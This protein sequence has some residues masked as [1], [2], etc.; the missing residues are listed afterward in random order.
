MSVTVRARLP[1]G[2][3][4]GLDHLE[5]TLAD[6]PDAVHVV[7]ALVRADTIEARPHDE[8]DPRC[9]KTVILHLEV[10]T[11]HD[12]DQADKAMRVVYETRTGKTELPFED[13]E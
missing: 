4:N 10:V 13:G 1:K 7:V 2:D 5:Q 8:D 12:G 6:D 3:T 11:G 9:V